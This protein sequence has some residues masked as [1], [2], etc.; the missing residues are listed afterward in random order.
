MTQEVELEIDEAKL[1]R[2]IASIVRNLPA[3]EASMLDRLARRAVPL[4]QST[5]PKKS[6][7]LARGMRPYKDFSGG[8]FKAITVGS[9]A[10][11]AKKIDEGGEIRPHGAAL[12]I[13]FEG[14]PRRRARGLGLDVIKR[15]GGRSLLGDARGARFTLVDS[16][17]IRPSRFVSRAAARL[18]PEIVPTAVKAVE[19]VALKDLEG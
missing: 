11:Y 19:E 6:G 9:R 17:T 1:E 14:A 13:P 12:A 15:P 3:A 10:R 18:R 2:Q 5:A 7:R 4:L 16:V 8:E